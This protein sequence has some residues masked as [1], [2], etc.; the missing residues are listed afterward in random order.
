MIYFLA[1]LPYFIIAAPLVV[2]MLWVV[3]TAIF[4]PII[5]TNNV[6]EAF[7]SSQ[8]TKKEQISEKPSDILEKLSYDSK[9]AIEDLFGFGDEG[10]TLKVGDV[11][12]EDDKIYQVSKN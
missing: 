3:F 2:G 10:A 4:S 7:E 5:V 11:V 6:I 9:Y 1:N 8:N 12:F